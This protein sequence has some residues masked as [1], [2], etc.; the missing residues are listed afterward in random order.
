MASYLLYHKTLAK[1]TLVEELHNPRGV[2]FDV[3][4]ASSPYPA[5]SPLYLK[6]L[7][8]DRLHNKAVLSISA[9]SM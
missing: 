8:V 6:K 9:S 5:L 4:G 7:E 1:T 2:P 3:R